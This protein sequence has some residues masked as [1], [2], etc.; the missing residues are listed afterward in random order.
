[1]SRRNFVFPPWEHFEELHLN[2]FLS[3]FSQISID[4]RSPYLQ[5]NYVVEFENSHFCAVT[6]YLFTA[7]LKRA[8]IFAIEQQKN[9]IVFERL[10]S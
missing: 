6:S 7:I 1:M 2:S 9:D 8:V 10:V 3:D 5:Q 4:K